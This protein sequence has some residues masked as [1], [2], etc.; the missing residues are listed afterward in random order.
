MADTNTTAATPTPN[1]TIRLAD[2]RR[3]GVAYHGD[4]AGDPV[5]VCHGTPASRLGHDFT[6]AAARQRRLR[7]ICLDRPG[8]GLSDP[9]PDRTVGGFADDV[10]AVADQLGH[11]RFAVLGYSGGGPYALA[12]GA[13]LPDRVTVSVLMAGVG[14]LDRPGA[15]E[16]LG[17]TD[18]QL[19]TMIERH[20]RRAS[21]F[22]RLMVRGA[23]ISPKS[24]VKSFRKEVSA[25]D[26]AAIDEIGPGML[27]FFV[28]AF[29]QGPAGP[30]LDYKLWAEPWDFALEDVA[31]P[32]HI[33]QGTDDN[34]VP[35][36]HAEDMARRIPNSTLHPLPRTG[37]VSIQ[38]HIG[39]ILDSVASPS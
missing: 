24:A 32:V 22:L 5:F 8:I 12:C 1:E 19:V 13:R 39:E 20:P 29:R 11:E 33:W 34:L 38:G 7:I 27:A 23:R 25:V 16:G 31:V 10:A 36:G 35:M 3:L 2:G 15:R 9:K 21:L 37:H 30:I 4:P 14:P 6:D 26:Q 17:K 18:L 28:E